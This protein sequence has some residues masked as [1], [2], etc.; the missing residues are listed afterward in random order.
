MDFKLEGRV[1]LVTGASI[2]I[3]RGIVEA[4]AREGAQTI[5]VA[6]RGPL[7]D[8]V[9]DAITNAGGKRPHLIVSDIASAEGVAKVADD[10]LT[11]YG[12]VDVLINNAGQSVA[13]KYD[14][15]DTLWEDALALNFH[16]GRRLVSRFAPGMR[17]RNWGRIVFVTGTQ[18]VT[19]TSATM[20]A[21]AAT[22]VY[23]KAISRE[24]GPHGITVNCVAPGR[25]NSEQILTRLHADPA[26]RAAFIKRE[27]PLGY[28][29][30]PEDLAALVTFLVSA[31]AR[32]ITGQVIAVDGGIG[33]FAH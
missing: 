5:A 12:K 17:E 27:V 3:G 30:E 7:L 1:C 20:P 29:G 8:E 9:A 32:Y 23:A 28:F 10:A 19:G 22:Q 2:G 21:K 6:R 13:A 11:R 25:I 24:L 15:G 14:S 26:E 33:R 16:A 4:L 18:E 31:Q